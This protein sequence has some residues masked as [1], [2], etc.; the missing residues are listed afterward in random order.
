[1]RRLERLRVQYTISLVLIAQF[2]VTS[3]VAML[4]YDG[5]SSFFAEARGYS[6]LH[7][8]FSEL[9]RVYG[10]DG[11]AKPV[12]QRLFTGAMVF[13]GAGFIISH[14]AFPGLFRRAEDG[15]PYRGRTT[16]RIAAILGG[17]VGIG[18]I[19][20]GLFPTDTQTLAHY[21]GV[22]FAFTGLLPAV[23]AAAIA[24]IRHPRAPVH[25]RAVHIGFIV[26]LM[27]YLWLIWFGPGRDTPTGALMQIV[28]QK[29]IVYLGIAVMTFQ[30]ATALTLVTRAIRRGE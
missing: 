10:F 6:F 16:A 22:Y 9:G 30:T 17:I 3:L 11:E 20:I 19:A 5:G 21:V 4:V 2:L 1:M 23:A 25:T 29:I 24:L 15:A 8:T 13:S 12:T 26:V 14:L 7:N 18:F 28:G 27:G